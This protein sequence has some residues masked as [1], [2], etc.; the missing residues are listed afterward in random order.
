MMGHVEKIKNPMDCDAILGR[1]SYSFRPGQVHDAKK[2][3]S[4]KIRR[5][6]KNDTL[7]VLYHCDSIDKIVSM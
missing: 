1:R 6:M 3:E 2:R 7:R 4:R 5:C